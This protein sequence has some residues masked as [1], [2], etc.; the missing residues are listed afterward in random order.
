MRNLPKSTKSTGRGSGLR[1]TERDVLSPIAAGRSSSA[2]VQLNPM[3]SAAVH[4][5]GRSS[6]PVITSKW[7]S[8]E[9]TEMGQWL[10]KIKVNT[11]TGKRHLC[12]VWFRSQE[13]TNQHQTI[14]FGRELKPGEKWPPEPTAYRPPAVVE[15]PPRSTDPT[16]LISLP[17]TSLNSAEQRI[18]SASIEAWKKANP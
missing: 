11:S 7:F 15:P 13:E 17:S 2:T 10:D 3:Y 4:T 6:G 18:V 9:L 16:Y 12:R 5:S 1:A 14:I 8:K